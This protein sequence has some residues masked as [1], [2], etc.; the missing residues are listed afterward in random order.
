MSQVI[1]FFAPL[2]L[3][4]YVIHTQRLLRPFILTNVFAKIAGW[5]AW[6]L[7]A[8]VL[9]TAIIIYLSCSCIDYIRKKI[10]ETL[11]IKERISK[12]VDIDRCEW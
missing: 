2:T 8:A 10:F 3:G 12:A 9:G 5:Q 7:V 4:V 11:R 1:G 6:A